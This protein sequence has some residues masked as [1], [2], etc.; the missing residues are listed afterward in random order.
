MAGGSLVTSS[1]GVPALGAAIHGILEQREHGRH[2][3]RSAAMAV[4]LRGLRRE[5]EDAGSL[6]AVQE[7]AIET[8]RVMREES[9]E[10]FAVVRFGEVQLPG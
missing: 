8:A 6:K 9:G 10:W 2:A 4:R 1:I 7:L 5:M 3:A